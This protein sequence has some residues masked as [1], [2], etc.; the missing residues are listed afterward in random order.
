[1]VSKKIGLMFGSYNPPHLGHINTAKRAKYEQDLDLVYMI[2]IAQ[3]PFKSNT[4]Q[5]DFNDKVAM[6]EIIS[7]PYSGWLSVLDNCHDFSAGYIDELRN[8][9]N[10]IKGVSDDNQNSE[11]YIVSGEDFREKLLVAMAV[12]DVSRHL[13]N[14]T[15]KALSYFDIQYANVVAERLKNA[16]EVLHKASVMDLKRREGAEV[17]VS[18]SKI[19]GFI[20]NKGE[21][22]LGLPN[23]VFNYINNHGLYID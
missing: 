17:D 3:S 9:K 8:F 15:S 18:S 11:I 4:L 5:A 16:C 7:E 12:L 1:M 2:P 6:C 21:G 14:I 20:K 10:T 22:V 19:R 23:D 13:S